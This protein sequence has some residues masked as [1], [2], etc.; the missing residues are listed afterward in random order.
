VNKRRSSVLLALAAAAIIPALACGLP[1]EGQGPSVA[2]ISPAD[3]STVIVGQQVLIQSSASDEKG[4]AR[5]ELLVNSVAVR[6]DPPVDG[7][8]TTFAIAQPWTPEAPGDV[9]IHVVAYNTEDRA[10]HPTSI[11]LHVVEG[12]AQI[13]PTPGP[14]QTPVP[15]VTEEGGCTLNASYVADLTV[16]DDTVLQPGVAFTKSWRI[17]NS[18]TCDWGPGFQL[19]FVE[20]SQLGAAASVAIPATPS[21]AT[22]DVTAQMMSPTEPGTYKSRWRLQSDQGQ[23][24]GSTIY[25]L[26]VV[27]EPVTPTSTSGPTPTVTPT[28]AVVTATAPPYYPDLDIADVKPASILEEVGDWFEIQVA[29]RNN[30]TAL[31]PPTRLEGTFPPEGGTETVGIPVLDPGEVYIATL[32]Y[33]IT[34]PAYGDGT[35]MVDS[36]DVVHETNEDNNEVTLPVIVD[37]SNLRVSELTLNEGDVGNLDGIG[38]SDFGGSNDGGSY[39]L[40]P[41]AGAVAYIMTGV[42]GSAHYAQI[43][44]TQFD[45]GDIPASALA[46]GTIIAVRT[47][48]GY[49]GFIRVE[50]LDLSGGTIHIFWKIWDWPPSN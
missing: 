46:V 12:S 28:P 11:T 33:H 38:A 10:S 5:V 19:V 21:G 22:V 32:Q 34:E 31:S 42:I 1:G 47:D 40:R 9:V 41:Q 49:R 23:A 17:R 50:T 36:E 24:F 48:T 14:T 26:I 15:D 44:P 7:T 16:P 30:S 35:I 45:A 20:G 39:Y 29:V 4:I 13:T 6:A 8:P 3:G 2:I 27:P 18:G 43:D 25:V 37:P